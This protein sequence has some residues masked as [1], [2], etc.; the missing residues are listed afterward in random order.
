VSKGIFHQNLSKDV[1]SNLNNLAELLGNPSDLQTGAYGLN[2][3]IGLA[4]LT[5]LTDQKDLKTNLLQPLTKLLTEGNFSLNRLAQ[6]LP[7]TGVK[8]HQDFEE[9]IDQLFQ[10]RTVCFMANQSQA[11]SFATQG[12][13]KHE[14]KEAKSERVVRGPREGFTE[15]IDENIGI[16]RRYIKDSH[17]RV[18]PVI[19]GRRSRTRLAVVYL[20]DIAPERLIGEVRSRLSAIDIDAII[21]SGYIEQLIKDRRASIF[22][23]TQST[24]RTDKVV[25]AIYEGRVAILVDQSPFAI[26]VPVTINELYQSTEDYYFDFWMGSFLRILR[27]LSNN[28]AVALPGLYVAL[29]AVNPELLPTVFA[30]SIAGSRAG[31]PFPLA[32]EV[33]FM[34]LAVEIFRE[35]SLRLPGTIGITLGVV[36]GVI[37]GLVG[38]QS[39][40]VSPATMVVVAVTAVASFTGSDYAVG[41]TW[42][43]LKYLFLFGAAFFGLF[44]LTVVGTAVLLHAAD[45]KSFGVSY[46]APW[47]PLQWRE[48]ADGPIR[49]PFWF[50]WLRPK[51]YRPQDRL[52][53]GGTKKEDETDE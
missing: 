13:A 29:V 42:R 40:L 8:Y 20:A 47:S 52:R 21:D 18:D 23:L 44:G 3:R 51:T 9:I 4:Y 17:L 26:I 46:L 30:L 41:I 39:G 28:L 53:T 27:L 34:E 36:A 7:E 6:F 38:V 32:L 50:R 10:G 43:L 49:S 1:N 35:A 15:T 37:L 5:G 24:E 14:L 19:L 33:L 2:Q 45:L 25:A 31:I 11:L 22:P 12:W 16:I 48:L